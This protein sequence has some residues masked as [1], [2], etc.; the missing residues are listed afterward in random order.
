[1]ARKP[2]HSASESGCRLWSYMMTKFDP[3][4]TGEG[5]RW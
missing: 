2:M 4:R 1:M 5:E 3:V